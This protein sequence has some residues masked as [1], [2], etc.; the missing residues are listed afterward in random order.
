M[1]P[2][3]C[4]ALLAAFDFKPIHQ[5]DRAE[6]THGGGEDF[7]MKQRGLASLEASADRACGANSSPRVSAALKLGC[8]E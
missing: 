4:R 7:V 5:R 6:K 2:S 1:R 3:G 8:Q